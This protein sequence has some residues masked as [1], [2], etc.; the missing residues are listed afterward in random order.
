MKMKKINEM[1][2]EIKPNTLQ[3]LFTCLHEYPT[4]SHDQVVRIRRMI[5]KWLVRNNSYDLTRTY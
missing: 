1:S 5:K 4:L 3:S 2:E